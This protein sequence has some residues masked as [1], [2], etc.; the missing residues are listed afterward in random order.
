MNDIHR[1]VRLSSGPLTLIA[2]RAVLTV[3]CI[4]FHSKWLVPRVT[5]PSR[6]D[7]SVMLMW[8]SI[9]AISFGIIVYVAPPLYGALLVTHKESDA[10]LP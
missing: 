5:T 3:C 8:T 7:R 6:D 1:L 2:Q 4:A 9:R 10:H